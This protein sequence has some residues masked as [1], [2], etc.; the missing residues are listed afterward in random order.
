[1]DFLFSFVVYSFSFVICFLS[2]EKEK[3]REK[4][5]KRE[6]KTK[7]GKSVLEGLDKRQHGPTVV[8]T[9]VCAQRWPKSSIFGPTL[10]YHH[11][12]S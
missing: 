11:P 2:E 1:M 8:D 5:K 7:I 3:D 6:K 10:Y 12:N 9:I 4:R